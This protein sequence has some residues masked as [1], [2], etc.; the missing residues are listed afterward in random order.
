M[1]SSHPRFYLVNSLD[2][3]ITRL[4]PSFTDIVTYESINLPLTCYAVRQSMCLSKLS[5]IVLYCIY[6]VQPTTALYHLAIQVQCLGSEISALTCGC[7]PPECFKMLAFHQS[8]T[9]QGPTSF[10][11]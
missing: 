1:E 5:P 6:L 2:M 10:Q 9:R 11:C 4:L 7:G 8:L 3:L